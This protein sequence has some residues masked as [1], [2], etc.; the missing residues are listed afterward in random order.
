MSESTCRACGRAEMVATNVRRL[1]GAVVVLGFVLMTV[2]V[3]GGAI[4]L[5]LLG[6]EDLVIEGRQRPTE[7]VREDLRAAGIPE[8][9]V[10]KAMGESEETLSAED[11]KSLDSEQAVAVQKAWIATVSRDIDPR[12]LRGG[13][14][15]ILLASLL[16]FVAGWYL[17]RKRPALQCPSCRATSASP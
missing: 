7:Q 9:L 12:M 5:L 8:P 10:A 13:T 14:R 17:R 3:L 11:L 2:S 4:G 1:P 16:G 6:G 15:L